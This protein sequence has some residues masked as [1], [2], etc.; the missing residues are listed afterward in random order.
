VAGEAVQAADEGDDAED[1]LFPNV[2]AAE[3]V[4]SGDRTFNVSA[5]I[6]SAYDTPE[7]YADAWRILTTDGVVLGV[8]ELGH[9]HQNEQPFT[10][11]LSNVSI[12]AEITSVIIEGRDQISGWGGDTVTVDVPG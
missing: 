12:P 6:D 11:S 10:R 4:P 7:R 5:T 3:L 2:I 9:D 8:R 1:E